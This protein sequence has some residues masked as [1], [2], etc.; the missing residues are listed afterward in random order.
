[1]TNMTTK[2][3]T[4]NH[5]LVTRALDSIDRSHARAADSIHTIRNS[6]RGA[7]ESSLD[8]FEAATTSFIK[9]ARKRLTTA[10]SATA[11]A[12]IRA[13]GAVGHAIERARLSRSE[14]QLAS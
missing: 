14:P 2:L 10:D 8:R 4:P 1:M 9:T 6:V 5:S 11:D 7:L 13:Q 12:I 3:D